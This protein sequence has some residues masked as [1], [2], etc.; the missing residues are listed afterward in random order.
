MNDL[1]DKNYID[2]EKAEGYR[3]RIEDYSDRDELFKTGCL[4]RNT[5]IPATFF[6]LACETEGLGTCPLIGFSS[7]KISEDLD[8][9]SFERSSLLLP[10]GYPEKEDREE[11]WRKKSEDIFETL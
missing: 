10:V 8:L 4:N 5:M 7:E 2:E 6:M 9:E 3:R 11:K 1:L